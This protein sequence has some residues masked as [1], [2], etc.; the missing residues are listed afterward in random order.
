M[1]TIE[2]KKVSV[3]KSTVEFKFKT[4]NGES[5][6]LGLPSLRYLD[7][8]LTIIHMLTNAIE[9]CENIIGEDWYTSMVN[10]IEEFL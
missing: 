1:I 5:Y 6:L 10:K 3:H 8:N 7:D 4:D 9:S 2:N